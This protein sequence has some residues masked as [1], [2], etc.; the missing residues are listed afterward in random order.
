MYD[1]VI[2]GSGLGGLLC[3][4]ILS[5]EGQKVCIVEKHSK[6]GGS[7]QT[8][9]R[10]GRIFDTGVH[11]VGGLEEGQNLHTYFK[12]F[13]I[14]DDLKIRRMDEN[15]FDKICFKNESCEYP[16]AVG[17]DNFIDQL[18]THFPDEREGLIQY[19]EYIKKTVSS[20]HFTHQ[21][22]ESMNGF[23]LLCDEVSIKMRHL[24]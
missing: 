9:K 11:Y 13:G 3:A 20:F 24:A 7:L 14:M 17:Y 23:I 22:F 1:A 8:F 19:I 21:F 15:A 18:A 2:V 16:L 10:D 5:K 12:Y 4:S 6:A